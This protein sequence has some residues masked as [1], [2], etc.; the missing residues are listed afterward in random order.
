METK[1]YKALILNKFGGDI[2]PG[3]R[4]FRALY[5]DQLLVKIMC[6]TIHPADLAFL[7]GTYG[8]IKP[9]IFP[10]VPGLEGCGEIIEVGPGVDKSYIGK[11]ANV[12]ALPRKG[13]TFDGVWAE[14]FI[15]TLYRDCVVY[16]E[17]I[18]YE[19]LCFGFGN[20]MT[21]L[22]FLDTMRKSN[23]KAA[24]MTGA[25]SALG[26]MFAKL[27]VN[28]NVNVVNVVRNEGHF[29]YFN[30]IGSKYMISTSNSNWYQEL[31]SLSEKLG[32]N[33]IFDCVGG[34]NSGR[35]LSAM[36]DN[37]ILYHFGNLEL[38]RI[39]EL[40]TNDFIVKCKQFKGWWLTGWMETLTKEEI[41]KYLEYIR[42]DL[43]SDKPILTTDYTES[44]NLDQIE[45]AFEKYM[46]NTS[47][48]KII[49]RPNN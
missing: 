8:H 6:A 7:S 35:F 28:E 49:I 5:K 12:F 37:S 38:K 36:P 47:A 46:T 18:E 22:G 26:K 27:C 10:I 43:I 2:I 15:A 39:G 40:D 20:P 48:G 34:D 21:A 3:E 24:V 11:R 41:L 19:K 33:L 4:E 9:E 44:F 42:N 1:K 30:A 45:Q 23:S 13:N 17:K 14:F 32:A 29:S 31:E 25:S 16:D